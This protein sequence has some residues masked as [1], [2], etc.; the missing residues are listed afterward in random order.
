ME[1]GSN[2]DGKSAYPHSGSRVKFK[3]VQKWQYHIKF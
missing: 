3:V 1:S 2:E